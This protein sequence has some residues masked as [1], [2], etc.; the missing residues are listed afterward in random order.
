MSAKRQ[1]LIDTAIN[2]FNAHGF[3]AVGIDRIA[4]EAKVTKKTMYHHFHSKEE[5]I[6]AA[7]RHHDALYRNTFMNNIKSHFETPYD[8]LLGI[9]DMAHQW[10]SDNQFYGCIFIN[11]VG[12]FADKNTPIKNACKAFKNQMRQFIEQLATDANAKDPENLANTL[13]ILLE[14]SIVTAQVS[15]NPNS[16]KQAQSAAKILIDLSLA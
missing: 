16:A 7:L 10:F 6:L 1:Q 4:K 3:H 5:L 12:E 2:L 8:R 13:A 9:F 11:A 14:G 15:G